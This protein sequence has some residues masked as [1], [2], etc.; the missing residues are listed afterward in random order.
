M[1]FVGG[2]G[3]LR[4]VVMGAII[5]TVLPELLRKLGSIN[6]T[7]ALQQLSYGLILVLIVV[8]APGG[9]NK[10]VEDWKKKL[11]RRSSGLDRKS[12]EGSGS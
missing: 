11:L 12:G 3:T 9:L 7:P 1:L 4:G 10:L 8:Y 2:V 6:I 5:F